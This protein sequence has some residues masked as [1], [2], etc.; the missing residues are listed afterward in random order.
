MFHDLRRSAARNLL[1]AGVARQVAMKLL[2]QATPSMF[3][4][5][6]IVNS[7][8]RREATGK[9]AEFVANKTR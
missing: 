2:G 6:A 7:S 5:Y 4:R 3:E 9:L 1:R 8:M